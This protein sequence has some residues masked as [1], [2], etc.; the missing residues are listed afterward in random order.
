MLYYFFNKSYIVSVIKIKFKK[1][2]QLIQTS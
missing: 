2:Q 1:H